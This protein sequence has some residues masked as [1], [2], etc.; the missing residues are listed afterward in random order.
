[1]RLFIITWWIDDY[2]TVPDGLQWRSISHMDW[3]FLYLSLVLTFSFRQSRFKMSVKCFKM[4]EPQCANGIVVVFVIIIIITD[5]IIITII[6]I[7]IIINE[8]QQQYE[9]QGHSIITY[10]WALLVPSLA[11]S[12]FKQ[13]WNC[14]LEI[15]TWQTGL[16]MLMG[17]RCQSRHIVPMVIMVTPYGLARDEHWF[18]YIR[19]LG[20]FFFKFRY[21]FSLYTKH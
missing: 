20:A 15:C 14:A 4:S 16:M 2:Q 3:P 11:S 18:W 19:F 21:I 13:F 17:D 6:T 12:Y 10:E 5:Q 8:Q 7:I 9:Q 1:M